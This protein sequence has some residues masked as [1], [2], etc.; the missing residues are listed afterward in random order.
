MG[1]VKLTTGDCISTA[2][3][4]IRVVEII[5][6]IVALVLPPGA[7][8]EREFDDRDRRLFEEVRKLLAVIPTLFDDF[9]VIA[10][11][12]KRANH[13][14][15]ARSTLTKLRSGRRQRYGRG[16]VAIRNEHDRIIGRI[17]LLICPELRGCYTVDYLTVPDEELLSLVPQRS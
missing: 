4:M 10:L 9:V 13:R 14:V 7:T 15:T 11:E 2:S 16:P 6:N 1:K 17:A 12:T 5:G 8:V 3:G